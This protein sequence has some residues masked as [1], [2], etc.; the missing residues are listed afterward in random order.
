MPKYAR[1]KIFYYFLHIIEDALT[2][3]RRQSWS[4]YVSIKNKKQ[5]KTRGKFTSIFSRAAK[6]STKN[7]RTEPAI[8]S[9][10]KELNM[11]KKLR[12]RMSLR[13]LPET[14]DGVEDNE[15]ALQCRTAD[16]LDTFQ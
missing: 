6:K 2:E 16:S 13:P 9:D 4:T 12:K 5:Q 14:P 3:M 11:S 10:K 1:I 7:E 15:H 8:K